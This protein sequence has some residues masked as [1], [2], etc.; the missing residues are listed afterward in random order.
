[1]ILVVDTMGEKDSAMMWRGIFALFF[2][3]LRSDAR[4][5]WVHASWFF[6]LIII[7]V[8]MSVAQAQ[9]LFFGAP[10]L[11]LFKYVTYC[12][13]AFVT[14]LGISYFSS[15]IS[16]EKEED[17]LGLMT[18]AGINPLGIL[19]GKS[20]TRLFQVFLLLAVQYP[21]TL[22]A[23]TLGG[24]TRE[25]IY[26]AY[27][28]LLAF[29]ILLANMGLFCSVVSRRNRTA[30]SLTTLMMVG[31]GFTPMIAWSCIAAIRD[32]ISQNDTYWVAMG[33]RVTPVL[34]WF[35]DSS[36][37][38]QLNEVINRIGPERQ[39]MLTPQLISN[40]LGGIAFFLL[41]WGL[42]GWMP[43]DT[44]SEAS[45]RAMVP[46]RTG[47]LRW[48]SAGRAWNTALAWKDFHFVAGGWFGLIVRCSL[49]LGLYWLVYLS[50]GTW[51]NDRFTLEYVR[52]HDVTWGYQFFVVPLFTIDVALCMSRLFHE[53]IRQQT[54]QSL[55][56]L[57]R[58]VN[59][60]VYS[61]LTGCV[62]GLL[63]GAVAVVVAF[64]F[65]TG[66]LKN[67]QDAIDEPPAWWLTANLFLVV[68]LCAMLS[69]YLR[70]GAFAVSLA[71]TVGSMFMSAMLLELLFMPAFRGGGFDPVN[72]FG[73]LA[74][75]VAM[76]CIA[77]HFVILLRL[78]ALGEK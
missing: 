55:L 62:V 34:Q 1:M 6:L 60:I 40:T 15:V 26:S 25:Q 42:F 32:Q 74:V 72:I 67:F 70:W 23:I 39:T 36:I 21:F 7:Y 28:A 69:L 49:Y 54:L 64:I 53:E 63:P 33:P 44:N 9:S 30:A 78:P 47:R 59:H 5:V 71:L 48:F 18:M 2:R 77:T 75:L 51:Q 8:A 20:T 11:L 76:A 56:M 19:L 61:K 41:S 31:Y 52:W 17:T 45:T 24:L 14:L 3:S 38:I 65:L 68:H 22:L 43:F 27:A 58:S 46:R 29:T 12:N 57:P 4:A 50:N 13:A 73:F 10:G 37:F 66:A 16:E 35:Y